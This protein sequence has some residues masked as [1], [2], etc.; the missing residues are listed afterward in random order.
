MRLTVDVEH[1]HAV[2]EGW[3]DVWAGAVA[4]GAIC[5]ARGYAGVSGLRG[6]LSV[7]LEI[8]GGE[9]LDSS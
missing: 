6:G 8:V 9:G 3:F 4:V 5:V 2:H 1:R 7:T